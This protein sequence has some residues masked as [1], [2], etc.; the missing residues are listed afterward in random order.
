MPSNPIENLDDLQRILTLEDPKWQRR[1]FDETGVVVLPVSKN[2]P[3]WEL[4]SSCGSADL[5]DDSEY[6]QINGIEVPD[7]YAIS[8]AEELIAYITGMETYQHALKDLDLGGFY[9]SDLYWSI[10]SRILNL[11]R[12]PEDYD[13]FMGGSPIFGLKQIVG[14][15]CSWMGISPDDLWFRASMVGIDECGVITLSIAQKPS[16]DEIVD[17]FADVLQTF[18]MEMEFK[19]NPH[20]K[21]IVPKSYED[22]LNS[23]KMIIF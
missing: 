4:V 13:P 14:P 3:Y 12:Y 10:Y 8:N 20:I 2:H 1:V 5:S 11:N 18:E 9:K 21:A 7:Y 22:V 6:L 23:W 16:L 15:G 19:Y 17:A